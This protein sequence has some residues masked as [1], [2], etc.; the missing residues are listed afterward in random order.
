MRSIHTI[1]AALLCA[2]SPM[3]AQDASV[4]EKN[5][6]VHSP[7]DLQLGYDAIGQIRADYTAGNYQSFLEEMDSAYFAALKENQLAGLVEMRENAAR[8]L[9]ENEQVKLQEVAQQMHAD[10][11]KELLQIA[12]QAKEN[13]PFLDKVHSI[14]TQFVTP[15]QRNAIDQ[16]MSYRQMVPGTGKDTDE[17][18]LIDLDLEYE[19]KTLHLKAMGGSDLA[20]KQM[21]LKMQHLDQVLDASKSF[22]NSSLQNTV[23][24][25]ARNFDERLAQ[26][27]D[28]QDLH[29]LGKGQLLAQNETEE[30]IAKSVSA[31]QEKVQQLPVPHAITH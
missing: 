4:V 7:S 11:E 1:L 25:Y 28:A 10:R 22:T 2:T 16:M 23:H 15:E 29:A 14:S 27:W 31:Y 6:Q 17:N 18:R 24:L 21:V 12:S 26:I 20:Q 8:T 13:S 5:L 19:F 9:P 3:M 30:Q